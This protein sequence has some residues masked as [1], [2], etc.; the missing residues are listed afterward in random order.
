MNDGNLMSHPIV[1]QINR[2]DKAIVAEDFDT[3]LDIY[4]DDAVLVIEPGKNAEGKVAIRKAFEAIAVYFKN[5]LQVQQRGIEVLEAGNT[6]LVLANTSVS[7][8][9]YPEV[10]RKA[11]YVFTKT[12][13]GH[14]LCSIDNSYGHEI[15]GKYT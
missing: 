15:I 1:E 11:T 10:I 2:A 7:A 9:N 6:A 4:T 13:Q 12:A 3:L 5:G 8:P 14:W